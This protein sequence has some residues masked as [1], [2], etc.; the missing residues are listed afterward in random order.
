M[1]DLTAPR[2]WNAALRQIHLYPTCP[3]DNKLDS[4][5]S[6]PGNFGARG[7]TEVTKQ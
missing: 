1:A 3:S 7:L 5:E 4:A 6:D 2:I